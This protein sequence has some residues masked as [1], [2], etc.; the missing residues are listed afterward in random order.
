MQ[1]LRHTVFGR[2][3][4]HCD[5]VTGSIVHHNVQKLVASRIMLL[6]TSER[7]DVHSKDGKK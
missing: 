1:L 7:I 4:S 3:T 2:Q 6:K 5:A